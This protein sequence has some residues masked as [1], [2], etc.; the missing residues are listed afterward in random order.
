LKCFAGDESDDIKG[1]RGV[2]IKK[3]LKYFPLFEKEKYF[4][5]QLVEE[6]YERKKTSKIKLYDSIINSSDIIYRNGRLMNLKKPFLNKEAEKSVELILHGVLDSETNMQEAMKMFTQYG[7]LNFL[8]YDN[9]DFFFSP[10]YRIMSK[11]KEYSKLINNL[12]L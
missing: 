11:E 10:Y 8:G 1:V 9:V 6:A 12:N 2:S 3:M 7:Y 4:Y 5:K